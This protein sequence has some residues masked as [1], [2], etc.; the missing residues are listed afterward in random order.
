MAAGSLE[1]TPRVL[2]HDLYTGP[3]E[4][5]LQMIARLEQLQGEY[6]ELIAANPLFRAAV[7]TWVEQEHD[8]E[9]TL[10]ALSEFKIELD[11]E[12]E[13]MTKKEREANPDADLHKMVKLRLEIATLKQNI[14]NSALVTGV[15]LEPLIHDAA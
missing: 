15:D 3:T 13:G 8:D 4:Q 12:V 11:A 14:L 5:Q 2:S 10:Y 9:H 6:A 7:H 1:R